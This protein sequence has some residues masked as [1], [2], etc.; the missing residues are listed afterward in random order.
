M[1]ASGPSYMQGIADIALRRGDDS[2]I[3]PSDELVLRDL[4]KHR[5]FSAIMTKDSDD[6]EIEKESI[7]VVLKFAMDDDIQALE[8]EGGLYDKELHELQGDVVPRFHG[9][10][11]GMYEDKEIA[12]MVFEW[13]CGFPNEDILEDW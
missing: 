8:R 11:H 7:P 12:C 10:Y 5:V 3:I 9:L 2:W 1:Q 13:C 6:D 4:G